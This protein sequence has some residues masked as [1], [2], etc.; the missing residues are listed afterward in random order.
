MRKNVGHGRSA[1]NPTRRQVLVRTRIPRS[2]AS[3]RIEPFSKTGSSR[4]SSVWAEVRYASVP[5]PFVEPDRSLVL[6]AGLE[7]YLR[8]AELSRGA[9]QVCE[10]RVTDAVRP[11]SSV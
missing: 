3:N 11:R 5:M 7:P 9:F 4:A 6:D 1:W 2:L 10:D 8:V